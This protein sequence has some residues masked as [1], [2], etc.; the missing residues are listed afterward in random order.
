MLHGINPLLEGEILSRL[1]KMGHGDTIL[2]ADANYPADASPGHVLTLAGSTSPQ[3]VEAVRSLIPA[4]SYVGP[5]VI[6]MQTDQP[7]L[8]PVQK[9]MIT[10]AAVESDR[11]E[12]LERFEFY[13][14]AKQAYLTIRTGEVRTYANVIIRKGVV[15]PFSKSSVSPAPGV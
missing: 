8:L 11:I 13:K 14:Q 5:S 9:E 2:I 4:D 3:V 6:L 10:A 12:L 15:L 7:D 1:Y